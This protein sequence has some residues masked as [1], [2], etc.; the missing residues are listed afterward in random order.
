MKIL[1]C[2][3]GSVGAGIAKQLSSEENSVTVIDDN[4]DYISKINDTLDVSTYIGVPAHP[5]VLEDAGAADAEMIIA[6]TTSDETNMVVCQVAHSLFNVPI[7]IA[8]IRNKNYLHP[9]WTDLYRHD[10]LPIDYIISP[11]R[12]VAEAIINRLHVPG[13][14]DSIPFVDG[15]VKVI[16]VRCERDCPMVGQ[17]ISRINEHAYNLKMAVI[18]INRKGKFIIPKIS[19]RLHKGDEVFFVADE[20]DVQQVMNLFGHEEKEARRVL[21]VGGGNIGLFIAEKLEEED[22]DIS[23]KLIEL[24]TKRAEYVAARLSHTTVLNG[25]SL[26][27]EI[28]SEANIESTET[29]I[30]VTND[31]EVNILSSLLAKRSGCK[32]AFTLVNKGGVYGPLISSLGIDVIV[33]PRE[34]TISSIL[35]HTRKGRVRAA[36]S[37]CNG[38]AEIIEIEAVAQSTVVGKSIKDMDIPSGIMVCA[39]S[40][41]NKT[42]ISDEKTIIHEKDRIIIISKTNL[43]H[44]VDRLFSARLDYF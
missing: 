39:I 9:A 38:E 33:D 17:H 40:R 5:T 30:S 25:N 15:K 22:H 27:Q 21:I 11:E 31:D 20:K 16:E 7:K 42:I 10:H 35:Q 6:V 24:N 14:M 34:M 41:N 3:A 28:L 18:G 19:E 26:D 2:G 29:V 23:T 44:K 13:A 32:K 37:I 4:I 8:R 36:H 43:V 12:E 1:V